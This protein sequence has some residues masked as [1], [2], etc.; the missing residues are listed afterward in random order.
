VIDATSKKRVRHCHFTRGRMGKKT[1]YKKMSI[2]LSINKNKSVY[3]LF[4]LIIMHT[5]SGFEPHNL[6]LHLA[7]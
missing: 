2:F 6:T 1:F 3:S 7:L 4:L 5:P